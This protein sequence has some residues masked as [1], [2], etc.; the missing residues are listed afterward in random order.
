M[1]KVEIV[2]PRHL[3][4]D[5]LLL[6]RRKGELHLEPSGTGFV[7]DIHRE[8]IRTMLPDEKT[9]FE[10]IFLE[11]LESKLKKLF[12]CLAVENIR[13]SFLS[14]RPIIDTISRTLDRHL[15][16]AETLCNKREEIK[17]DLIEL[18]GYKT[19]L[20]SVST[21]LDKIELTPDLDYI[22]ITLKDDKSVAYLQEGLDLSSFSVIPI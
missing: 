11:K 22:G 3:L 9:L 4:A 13:E 18:G 6:V 14:P 10:K 12:T 8:D 1:S 5:T 21:L 7:D 19:F 2:G 16:M 20:A 15:E 17:H